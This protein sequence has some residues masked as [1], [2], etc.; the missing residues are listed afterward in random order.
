[1]CACVF[2]V[3]PSN[4]GSAVLLSTFTRHTFTLH[5]HHHITLLAK[6]ALLLTVSPHKLYPYTHTTMSSTTHHHHVTFLAKAALLLSCEAEASSAAA[7]LAASAALGN[8]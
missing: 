6:A 2:G 1:M 7:F 3:F 8:A 5:P 4:G